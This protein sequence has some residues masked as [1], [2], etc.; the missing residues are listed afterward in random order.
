[1]N[2]YEEGRNRK[3]AYYVRVL[4]T[5]GFF[6][7]LRFV[8][9]S[10]KLLYI[11]LYDYAWSYTSPWCEILKN[12]LRSNYCHH[13]YTKYRTTLSHPNAKQ[14]VY[15]CSCAHIQSKTSRGHILAKMM[16]IGDRRGAKERATMYNTRIRMRLDFVFTILFL[17]L[18]HGIVH[19]VFFSFLFFLYQNQVFGEWG[20]KAHKKTA[21]SQV[22]HYVPYDVSKPSLYFWNSGGIYICSSFPVLQKLCQ[23]TAVLGCRHSHLTPLHVPLKRFHIY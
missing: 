23:R 6:A 15:V 7:F 9:F 12:G 1:M 16:F 8:R 22:Q 20:L 5:S 19:S 21:A 3:D 18:G 4:L 10:E 17:H 13:A 2:D 14:L 11:Y